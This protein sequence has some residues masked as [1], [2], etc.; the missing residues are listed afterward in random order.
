MSYKGKGCLAAIFDGSIPIGIVKH[1]LDTVFK[2]PS[3]P[4]VKEKRQKY[5]GQ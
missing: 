4:V 5:E 3:E 2:K 1:G